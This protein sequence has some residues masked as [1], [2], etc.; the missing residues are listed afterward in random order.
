[1][2]IAR[3]DRV[4]ELE[5]DLQEAAEVVAKA[6]AQIRQGL[7]EEVVARLE[8]CQGSHAPA[9]APVAAQIVVVPGLVSAVVGVEPQ[10]C[11]R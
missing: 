3:T 5:G 2:V 9:K 11:F 1:M 10:M 7:E 4:G 6:V 8:Q